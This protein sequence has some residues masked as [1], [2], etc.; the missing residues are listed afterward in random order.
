MSVRYSIG[1]GDHEVILAEDCEFCGG[2]VS[3]FIC[4][5]CDGYGFTVTGDGSQILALVKDVLLKNLVKDVL[6]KRKS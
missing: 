6:H 5:H 1:H 3:V 4:E 2:E